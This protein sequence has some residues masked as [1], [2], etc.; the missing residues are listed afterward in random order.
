MIFQTSNFK[1]KQFLDL[2][3]NDFNIIEP[4]Q[5]KEEP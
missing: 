4:S 1:K 2:L 5:A 3:D